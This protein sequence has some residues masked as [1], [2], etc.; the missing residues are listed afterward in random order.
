MKR[1]I[2]VALALITLL[3]FGFQTTFCHADTDTRGNAAPIKALP[4][5]LKGLDVKDYFIASKAE[6]VGLIQTVIG[7]VVVLHGETNEAY[8]AA[9]GDAVFQTA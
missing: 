7:H 6:P 9:Q 8:F 5:D 4:E 2:F 3:F 1:Y